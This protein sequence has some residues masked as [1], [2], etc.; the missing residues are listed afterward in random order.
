[1]IKEDI[2]DYH[3]SMLMNS[4]QNYEDY[5][6]DNTHIFENIGF[7]PNKEKDLYLNKQYTNQNNFGDGIPEDTNDKTKKINKNNF[8]SKLKSCGSINI[9]NNQNTDFVDTIKK[10]ISSIN[11]NDNNS[12]K[13]L[14][15]RKRIL[16]FTTHPNIYFIFNKGGGEIRP[17]IENIVIS[18][19]KNYIFNPRPVNSR[20]EKDENLIRKKIKSSFLKNLFKSVNKKIKSAGSKKFFSSLDEKFRINPYKEVNKGIF[21]LTFKQLILKYSRLNNIT[22]SIIPQQYDNRSVLEYLEKRKEICKVSNY[23]IFKDMTIYQIYDEYLKSEEFENV[24]K[25]LKEKPYKYQYIKKL[26]KLAYNLTNY[27]SD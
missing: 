2:F 11:N 16:F 26:I 7:S 9:S 17:F 25:K 21:L 27:Y 24:I 14:I 18:N 1:M 22:D 6:N 19:S 10:S 15:G 5:D 23:D 4:S 8:E 12:E 20:F 13:S 3:D